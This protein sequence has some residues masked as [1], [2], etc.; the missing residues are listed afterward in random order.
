MSTEKF[1]S[2][3]VLLNC[4]K[5][6]QK[7]ISLAARFRAAL[8]LYLGAFS[9]DVS[10]YASRTATL[11]L[12]SIEKSLMFDLFR[13]VGALF[14]FEATMMRVASPCV[15]VGDIHGQIL[16]LVRI[17]HTFGLPDKQRY[18]FLGDIVDRG[19][20]SV[21]TL[22]IVFLLKVL[23]PDNVFV[24]RGNHE[25]QFLCSQCGFMSQ[26]F[27]CFDD[28]ELYRVV[29][30]AFDQ[31]PLAALIDNS[32]LC[33]H[34][35][36]G[37]MLTHLNHIRALRRPIDNY[38]D[39]VV[40]SL[41][42][43]DPSDDVDMYEPSA[44]G[45]GYLFGRQ[46]CEQFLRTNNLR[47]IIRGH[48]CV[49]HGWKSHFNNQLI[50]VF[51]ASNYCGVVNNEAA[52]MEVTG[53]NTWRIRQFP[54]LAWLERRHVVFKHPGQRTKQKSIPIQNK[55]RSSESAKWDRIKKP[56]VPLQTNVASSFK[57][58]SKLT[59]EPLTISNKLKTNAPAG[60]RITIRP[61]TVVALTRK[62]W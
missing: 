14:S 22:V 25:F 44:R 19:E 48:E 41:V 36:I 29:S 17:L 57:D 7:M 50:T 2:I 18:V 61:K 27:D 39:D 58:L 47:M 8:D 13:Q 56:I 40:D 54:Q 37:P 49:E 60:K 52:V 10:K 5:S 32:M 12:P 62:F 30:Q 3:N 24:I 34:G 55:L 35:G 23:W 21:E 28:A 26:M 46:A 33:V 45:S 16:D 15:I 43:S 42:W 11:T 4:I 59:T 53:A 6:P 51:S 38:G 20:F 31:I 1:R 9:F